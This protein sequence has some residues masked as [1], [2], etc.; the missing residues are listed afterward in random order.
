V[1]R[2]IKPELGDACSEQAVGANSLF[3]I[4]Y[5]MRNSLFG[6]WRYSSRLE[7]S[8][9]ELCGMKRKRKVPFEYIEE[10]RLR[11]GFFV[12]EL[13]EELG[14]SQRSWYRWKAQNEAPRWVY[15]AVEIMSG[16][17]DFFGWKGWYIFD[18]VL[19]KEDL[20][21]KYYK[22]TPG[23]LAADWFLAAQTQVKTAPIKIKQGDKRRRW[24]S[25]ASNV[26][27]I[28]QGIEAREQR[29]LKQ[30]D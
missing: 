4:I 5:I 17:L 22:K 18:G 20:N 13:C 9:K 6:G 21:P 27:A 3:N 25:S 26:I 7:Q 2:R 8:K 10:T 19:Y 16:K 1:R 24:A 11:A 29:Y 28:E 12:D 14:V 15:R 30:Q 23:E